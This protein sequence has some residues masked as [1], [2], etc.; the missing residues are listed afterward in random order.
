MTRTNFSN[1]SASSFTSPSSRFIGVAANIVFAATVALAAFSTSGCTDPPA[2]P[3]MTDMAITCATG[4]SLCGA[5]CVDTKTNTAHCG[6]CDKACERGN[7]CVAGACT[8]DCPKSQTGCGDRCVSD[9][10]R[11]NC[12]TCGTA[13]KDGEVCVTGKCQISCPGGQKGLFWHVR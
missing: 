2:Q 11:A 12:G 10:D 13:C 5:S 6:A 4:Q 7:Y 8:P 3:A 9:N 1:Q